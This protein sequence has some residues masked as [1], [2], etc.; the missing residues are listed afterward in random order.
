VL[1][2]VFA[3]VPAVEMSRLAL[4]V[5]P[6][7]LPAM[8]LAVTRPLWSRW[9]FVACAYAVVGAYWLALRRRRLKPAEMAP[10]SVP[11]R[12]AWLVAMAIL[13]SAA[14]H[15]AITAAFF[16]ILLAWRLVTLPPPRHE[17]P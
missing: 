12:I 10:A 6:G 3:A 1:T 13:W 15:P 8:L 2:L 4:A 9:P 16:A 7:A 11:V 17:S 14:P 5:Q